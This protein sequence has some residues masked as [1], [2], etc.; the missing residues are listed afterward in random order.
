MIKGEYK[1][2][3]LTVQKTP[4]I[5]NYNRGIREMSNGLSKK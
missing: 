5:I 1:I 2:T 4:R 3:E